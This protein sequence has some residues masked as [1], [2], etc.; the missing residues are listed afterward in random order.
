MAELLVVLIITGVVL[1]AAATGVQVVIRQ[2]N[3]TIL[4]TEAAQRGRLVLDSLMRQI[5]SQVCLDVGTATE[6]IEP[7]CGEQELGH[8]LPR[9][10]A[11]AP[12][13][14]IKRQL[15]L[16]PGHQDDRPADLGRDVGAVGATPT[17]FSATA[18]DEDA[19]P[20]GDLVQR[21]PP[22]HAVLHLLRLPA[23]RQPAARDAQARSGRR[24]P[25]RHRSRGHGA[26]PGRHGDPPGQGAQPGNLDTP[27]GQRSPADLRPQQKHSGAD[28]R[29]DPTR[30]QC[31]ARNHHDRRDAGDA[32]DD[33]R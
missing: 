14:R 27:G 11:T 13:R 26:H 8:L 24:R 22:R 6:K 4:R 9:L 28:L 10:R 31:R 2:S 18:A 17:T 15:T 32:R 3:G 21:R 12:S 16:R 30:P 20:R 25:E 19:A 29:D 5:R 1:G 23:D 7:R 33:G